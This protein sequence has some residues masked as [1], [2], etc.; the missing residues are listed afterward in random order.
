MLANSEF[1][2]LIIFIAPYI[3]EYINSI[4]AQIPL[5]KNL[6]VWYVPVFRFIVIE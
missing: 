5:I 2:K 4:I 6:T 3:R 1:L